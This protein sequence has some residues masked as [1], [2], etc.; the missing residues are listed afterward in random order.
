[1]TSTQRLISELAVAHG[2]NA[3]TIVRAAVHDFAYGRSA[4]QQADAIRAIQSI[5]AAHGDENCRSTSDGM[6]KIVTDTNPR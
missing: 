4:R 2:V 1:M 5:D 3:E 6:T